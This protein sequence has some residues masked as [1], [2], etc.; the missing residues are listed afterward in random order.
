MKRAL[1]LSAVLGA[2][3]Q[4]TAAVRMGTAKGA[5]QTATTH[6][7]KNADRILSSTQK[8]DSM[9]QRPFAVFDIDGTLIRWQLYHAVTDTLA[10]LGYLEPEQYEEIRSAR[11]AWKMR[12]HPEAF[13]TY[14]KIMVNG[15]EQIIK[16][17][18]VAQFDTAVDEVIDQYKDQVY[19]YSRQL[20]KDL[21]TKNYVLLAISG[22]QIELVSRIAAY[23]GFDDVI[24]TDYIKHQGKF[25]GEKKFYA[26]D[27]KV[28]LQKLIDKHNLTLGG[29]IA[30]GDSSSDI[31][32]LQMVEHPIAFNPERNLLEE[33]KKSGWTIVLE[34]KNTVYRLE[35][36]DGTYVLA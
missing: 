30:I 7:A 19:T 25:T 2:G 18:T 22:S 16:K 8:H 10:K 27:K 17:L 20:I 14:E 29:S 6:S 34:R 13:K 3:E 5:A 21:K 28:A 35:P 23:Y 33:A 11:I 36:Q 32:M 15:F 12:A 4:R 26:H 1:R 31:S 24:G 9:A